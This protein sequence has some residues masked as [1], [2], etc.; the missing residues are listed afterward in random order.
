[1]NT[2]SIL[3]LLAGL[4]LLSCGSNGKAPQRSELQGELDHVMLAVRDLESTRAL[5]VDTLGFRAGPG[6]RLSGGREN[7][8]LA[9]ANRTY[10]EPITVHDGGQ[11]SR[12]GAFLAKQEGS[13][14]IALRVPSAERTAGYLREWGFDVTGPVAGGAEVE[15]QKASEI[16]FQYVIFKQPPLPNGLFFVEYNEEA[17]RQ[18][19]EKLPPEK[20]N[21]TAHPNTASRLRAVWVAVDDL[22][23]ATESYRSAGLTVGDADAIPSLDAE[24][25]QVAVGDTGAILLV[26]AEDT[27]GPVASFLE[28]RGQGIMGVTLEVGDL[29]KAQEMVNTGLHPD[30]VSYAGHF[31]RS[32]MIPA[33]RCHGLFIEMVAR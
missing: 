31:G 12:L 25:R 21:F 29:D 22:D 4:I 23:K 24:G 13:P 33:P 16:M 3:P 26:D 10:L 32:I 11:S 2:S 5:F 6:G 20:R 19:V 27:D 9:F 7:F 18:A 1:M 28:K 8:I 14:A 30:V 17:R 15:G